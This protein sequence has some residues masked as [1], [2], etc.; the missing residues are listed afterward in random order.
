MDR[1]AWARCANPILLFIH[2]GPGVSFIPLAGAFQDPWEKH[3]TVVQWEQRRAG[4]T[5]ASND[6]ELQRRTMNI[7]QM[8]QDALDVANYLR[9]RFHRD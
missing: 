4:K 8:E 5:Y 3:F 1:S 6:K 7:P 9:A 2:G